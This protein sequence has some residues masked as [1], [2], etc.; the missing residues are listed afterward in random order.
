V[1]TSTSFSAELAYSGFMSHTYSAT[2]THCI[3]STKDRKNTI[4]DELRANLWAYLIGTAQN[5][6]I[7]PIAVGRTSNHAH[8][9][10]RVPPLM[11]LSEAIQR[12]KANSSRWM[13][14]QR[15]F[16][17]QQGYAAFSVSPSAVEP[18][19]QYV[20]HQEEHH[21]KRTFEEEILELLRKSG[22]P[23][24]AEQVFAA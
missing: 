6:K 7:L 12:L 8:L 16:E 23:H 17:W 2:Y 11:P 9:L 22:V 4:S 14:E 15:P 1:T 13:G 10:L 18:V 3:F 20:L 21:R 24:D 5:L 19:K